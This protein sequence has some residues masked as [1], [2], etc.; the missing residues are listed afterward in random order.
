MIDSITSFP[1]SFCTDVKHYV[2][3]TTSMHSLKSA[4]S[5]SWIVLALPTAGSLVIVSGQE[6]QSDPMHLFDPPLRS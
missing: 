4:I 5:L 6:C 1:L 2:A 3:H